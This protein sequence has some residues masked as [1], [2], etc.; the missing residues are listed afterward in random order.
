MRLS[1]V[2]AVLAVVCAACWEMPPINVPLSSAGERVEVVAEAPNE[3]VYEPFQE[4]SVQ[5]LGATPREAADTARHMLRNR[6]GELGGGF[7][8][9]EDSSASTA[10]DFS[11]RTVVTMK[12]HAY[13]V[14][15]EPAPARQPLSAPAPR[16]A[17]GGPD[18]AR[19]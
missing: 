10:W 6:A 15:E 16:D 4:I 3:D 11:G 5:A 7:V 18:A 19:R 14:K 12:G 17:A 2:V 8:S 13:R 9:I 1:S